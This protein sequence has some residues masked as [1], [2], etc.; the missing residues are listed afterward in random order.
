MP[1]IHKYL[2]VIVCQLSVVQILQRGRYLYKP[3]H[4]LNLLKLTLLG[5]S[6]VYKDVLCVFMRVYVC[7]CVC[8]GAFHTFRLRAANAPIANTSD[9]FD[10][11][12]QV[13]GVAV[14]HY[15][16]TIFAT[17]SGNSRAGIIVTHRSVLQCVENKSLFTKP[18][19]NNLY[20]KY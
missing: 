7:V 4:H 11:D 6:L 10:V 17:K 14:L 12:F 8:V 18:I 16:K 15:K 2:N 3:E 19:S 5:P 1:S 9:L 20:T 13:A